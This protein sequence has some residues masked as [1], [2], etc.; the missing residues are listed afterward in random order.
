MGQAFRRAAA[1]RPTFLLAEKR[2][3]KMR[4]WRVGRAMKPHDFASWLRGSLT[5]HPCADSELARIHSGHPLGLFSASSPPRI[6][7]QV[8][9]TQ[10]D[11][12]RKV[13]ALRRVPLS[14]THPPVPVGK[15]WTDQPL[16]GRMRDA[17]LRLRH[18]MC[19]QPNPASACAPAR[20]HRAGDRPSGRIFWLLFSAREK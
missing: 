12:L 7:R 17:R 9:S 10:R 20:L 1:R 2:R 13:A 19:L 3:P 18:R 16:A 8:K 15:C 4:P 11:V 5:A 14:L 6:G